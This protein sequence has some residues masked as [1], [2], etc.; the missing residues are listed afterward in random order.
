MKG[1]HAI[2]GVLLLKIKRNSTA[3]KKKKN[4]TN[5]NWKAFSNMYGS[6]LF[7]KDYFN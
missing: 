2:T 1:S 3:A 6:E 7:L 5:R 4:F